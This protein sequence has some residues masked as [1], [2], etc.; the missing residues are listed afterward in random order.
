[1]VYF[2]DILMDLFDTLVKVEIASPGHLKSTSLV[3][4]F[5]QG[6]G[7]VYPKCYFSSI[8]FS[9]IEIPHHHHDNGS[10]NLSNLCSLISK[11]DH[12]IRTRRNIWYV[13]KLDSIFRI[14]FPLF[15]CGLQATAT[16]LL[17]V[18]KNMVQLCIGGPGNITQTT[19]F[20]CQTCD[21]PKS[22]YFWHFQRPLLH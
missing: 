10:N 21:F 4:L 14:L 9:W 5:G 19:I 22:W 11:P 8:G 6:S 13:S 16:S 15:E 7:N 17:S 1:M 3:T 18:W 12:I 20:A 2:T